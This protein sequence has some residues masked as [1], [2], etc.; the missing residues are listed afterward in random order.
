MPAGEYDVRTQDASHNVPTF[1][2]PGSNA[3]ATI[4]TTP[5]SKPE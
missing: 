4:I 1:C 5:A 3:V 2:S